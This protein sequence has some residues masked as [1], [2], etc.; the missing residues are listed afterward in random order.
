MSKYPLP[1]GSAAFEIVNVF[2]PARKIN[3]VANFFTH[4]CAAPWYVYAE[5]FLPAF[6][7]L[8]ITLAEFGSGDILRMAAGR[9]QR[10]FLRKLFAKGTRVAPTSAA[11]A[12]KFFWKVDFVVQKAFFWWMIA[13]LT[14]DG[15]YK[16]TTMV[17]KTIW[18]QGEGI[19]QAEATDA[20][21]ACGPNWLPFT[22]PDVLQNTEPWFYVG[23]GVSL[24]PSSYHSI[25]TVSVRQSSPF[26]PWRNY[27]IQLTVVAGGETH[28]FVSEP[29]DLKIGVATDVVIAGGWRIFQASTGTISWSHRIDPHLVPVVFI[30]KAHIVVA[31]EGPF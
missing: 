14:I 5:L 28:N 15:L 23:L 20:A 19:L 9:P 8:F 4:P 1:P 17:E 24:G 30:E 11:K 29:V 26:T 27:Q 3:Y 18:C 16:W 21:P 10:R 7:E 22:I 31:D 12:V 6:A 2:L 25:L 13:D